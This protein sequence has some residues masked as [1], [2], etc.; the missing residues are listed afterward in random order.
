ML[1]I[2]TPKRKW[3]KKKPNTAYSGKLQ[4]ELCCK[5]ENHNADGTPKLQWTAIRQQ[6]QRDR[7]K[8]NNKPSQQKP[9]NKAALRLKPTYFSHTAEKIKHKRLTKLKHKELNSTA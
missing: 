8:K 7:K 4:F 3:Q 2:F 9:R 6:L 1:Y 5:Y